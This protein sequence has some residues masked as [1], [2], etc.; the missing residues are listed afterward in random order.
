[1]KKILFIF[2][3]ILSGNLNAQEKTALSELEGETLQSSFRLNFIPVQMPSD[4]FPQLKPTM[5]LLGVHYQVPLNNWLYGGVGMHAA[6]TGDQG[7]L[8]TLGVELGIKKQLFKNVFADVNVHFGGGG[9][10]RYLVNDGAFINP[11]IGL[12]FQQKKYAFGV[13]YSHLN[14][15]SGEIRSNSVSFFIE[16]PSVLRFSEYKNSEKQFIAKNESA[17]NFWRKPATKNALQVRFDFFKPIGNSRKD[18]QSPL[19]ETLAVLGFEYQKYVQKNTF[20]F[21]HTDAIYKG[22]R[23]GFMDLFL[24]VG[25]HPYQNK[26]LN[27]FTKFSLGAAGGRIA[28]EGGFMTY[29]SVGVDL[30]LTKNIAFSS[31][32]GYYKALD[33][34]LEAYTVGFGFKYYSNS[35]GTQKNNE[36]QD[37]TKFKTQGIKIHLQNQTYFDVP[38]TDS[39]YRSDNPNVDLQLI[40]FKVTYNLN[41]TFYATGEA[42]YAYQGE[43]GGYAHGM[44]GFGIDS[45]SFFKNKVNAFLEITG[46][47]AGGAGVDTGE[48]LVIRPTI[49]FNYEITNRISLFA[50][51]GKMF[52]PT[53]NL[54][55]KN[56]NIGFSF[57]LSTLT[58]KK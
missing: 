35:G 10:Y 6:L 24:G 12:K 5:G 27:I 19:T 58:A 4:A 15:Y 50:S 41:D 22:L 16:I 23:A 36:Q 1:M 7:G 25:Y 31:H 21:I 34:D 40:T 43:S 3:I 17:E 8:F 49:G 55:V 57:G 47:A 2:L 52:S 32:A 56:I 14:F 45:P 29:P 38:K 42:G 20:L 13:Q 18:D 46:G 39:H 9:G 28:P 26:Y 33:G 11:N 51:A 48:G 53:G 30:K 37:F 44:A 54:N